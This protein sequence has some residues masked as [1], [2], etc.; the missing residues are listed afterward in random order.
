MQR[1]NGTVKFYNDDEG[2]GF[3]QAD[4]VDY[5]VHATHLDE[6]DGLRD[7]DHVSFRPVRTPDGLQA[8][9]VTVEQDRSSDRLEGEVKFFNERRGFGFV[10]TGDTEYFVHVTNIESDAILRDGEKVTFKPVEG[11]KGLQALDVRR[12]SPPELE[13][14][15]GT[16]K[17]F[18]DEKG[19]GFVQRP[20]KGDVFVHVSDAIADLESL[21]GGSRV[22]FLAWKGRD[23]RERGYEIIVLEGEDYVAQE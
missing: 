20:G 17:D 18:Y 22:S 10:R 5:F 2:F 14:Q 6:A 4:D 1:K 16:V 23:G 12:E 7:G 3:V 15:V 8:R 13:R 11:G 21:E 9:D 19:Y